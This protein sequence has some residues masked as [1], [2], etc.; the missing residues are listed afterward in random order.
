MTAV[1]SLRPEPRPEILDIDIYVPG[2]SRV[3]GV[4]K[5]HKLSSNESPLGPSP[6]AIDAYRARADDLA[7]YPDGSA[8]VLREAIA[9]R[10][11]LEPDRILCGNGSDEILALLAHVFLRPGDEGVYSA[12]GFLAYPIAIRAAGATAVVAPET[13]RTA[14]VDALLGKVGPRTKIVY[15][16]NPNNPTG[17]YLPY[18]EIRRLHAALPADC[19]L[20]L[21]AAYAE[22]VTRNDYAAGLE[23]AASCENVVMT[24]TFSKIHGLASLR[25]GWSYGPRRVA[26]AINRVR[27]PFNLSGP[28]IAAGAASLD[29]AAHLEAAVAHNDRWLPWLSA[30]IGAL[31]I[32]PTPSVA[33]FVLL[34]FGRN[35]VGT[36]SEADA[37]LSARGYILRAMSAYGLPQSLRLTVGSAE[38]NRGVVEALAEFVER[39][40][41]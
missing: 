41:S 23:L 36:A 4:A 18:A 2:R 38:A 11:G 30:S 25:I 8:R 17:T 1:S 3:E 15:L 33:N 35:G 10:F 20:V 31:G 29:D 26:D 16:A 9:R 19:L 27:S 37:F 21:D 24:R 5:V 13:D 40:R 39:S 34:T 12:H 14:N 6:K 28:A 32:E 22:Y 7:A